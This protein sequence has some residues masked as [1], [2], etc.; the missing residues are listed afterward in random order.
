MSGLSHSPDSYISIPGCRRGDY[1]GARLSIGEWLFTGCSFL[2]HPFIEMVM[3][4]L[5][6][7]EFLRDY[8]EVEFQTEVE[9]LDEEGFEDAH[10]NLRALDSH[11]V[12][13]IVNDREEVLLQNDGHHGWTLTAFSVESSDD[14]VVTACNR[15][16]R[17]TGTAI[18]INGAERVR[19]IDYCL[20]SEND[21]R[22]SIYNVVLRASP[23]E[24]ETIEENPCSPHEDSP[25]LE[26]F[27]RVP[28]EQKESIKADIRLFLS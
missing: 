28:E 4:S 3:E 6:D 25:E 14:W 11:V 19:R 12:V 26:W 13:G 2:W 20:E 27:N 9:I 16:K 18:E 24:G 10:E 23:V 7:P 1:A 5:S 17:L 8:D 15:V 22:I 21:P